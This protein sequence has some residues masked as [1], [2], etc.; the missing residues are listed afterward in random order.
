MERVAITKGHM[1]SLPAYQP[2]LHAPQPA[3]GTVSSEVYQFKRVL[4]F[5]LARDNGVLREDH[6]TCN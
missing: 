3:Q 6:F 5:K 4:A 2:P 1:V